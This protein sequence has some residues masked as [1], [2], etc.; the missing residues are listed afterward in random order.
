MKTRTKPVLGVLLALLTAASIAVFTQGDA[1]PKA[2]GCYMGRYRGDKVVHTDA[3]WKKTLSPEAYR[4]LR[5]HDTEKA[6]TGLYWDNHK[7]GAYVCAG[8]GLELFVSKAKFNSGTGW[9]SF[10]EPIYPENVATRPDHSFG[11]DRTEVYC[12]RCGGHLGH[13]FQDGP[14]PTGLRYC[15]NSAAVSFI[16]DKADEKR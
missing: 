6:C 4:I 16:A 7:E 11:M 3:E 9:P 15:I 2:K 14:A 5:G 1:A 13:V 10:F 12:P 8:C